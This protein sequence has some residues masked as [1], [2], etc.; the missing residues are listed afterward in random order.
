MGYSLKSENGHKKT[1]GE[2]TFVF[3][4]KKYDWRNNNK[5]YIWN[6]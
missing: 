4:Y 1:G 5:K 3:V 6:E 2:E